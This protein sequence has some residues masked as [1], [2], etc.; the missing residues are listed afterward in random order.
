[1]AS[2]PVF[3]HLELTSRCNKG[4]DGCWMCGRR[5]MERDHPELCDWGDMPL[6]FALS[7]LG[8]IPK[9]AVVQLH[10]NGE[11]LLYPALGSVIQTARDYDL[12]TSLNT[13]A[14]RLWE[15]RFD[16]AELDTL[17]I[18][19]IENDPEADE[20]LE[21][22]TRYAAWNG[23]KP[24]LILRFLGFEDVN[25]R[26]DH[27]QALRVT[28]TLHSPDGSRDYKKPVTIPEIGI[29]LELLTHLAID[30]HGNISVCVRFDPAGD[31]RLGN[32]ENISIEEAIY[33]S[34]RQD[35]IRRHRQG[36][37]DECPGCDRCHFWGVP[38]G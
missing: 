23:Q 29:C 28:R 15:S 31:L 10:N 3:Y 34:K 32:I 2:L 16:V 8:Q 30:R 18:S 17:V 24:R 22:L 12:I 19:V 13:N 21:I 6:Y 11:P 4:G 27:I 9:G 14:K 20:Q 37:R 35:Y 1:M 7:V 33:G 5:K 36:R 26:Y 38:I 25:R